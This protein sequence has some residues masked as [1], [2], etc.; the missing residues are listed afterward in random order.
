MPKSSECVSRGASRAAGFSGF[1]GLSVMALLLVT[2]SPTAVCAQSSGQ[3]AGQSADPPSGQAVEEIIVTAQRRA[4]SLQKVPIAVAAITGPQLAKQGI[5]DVRDLQ[6]KIPSLTASQSGQVIY[7]LRGVGNTAQNANDEASVAL[8]VDGV[9]LY[10][11]LANTLTLNNVER[12]EVLK[13][14]Q[15]TLFGRNTTGGVIQLITRDPMGPSN[16]EGHVGYGNY[17]TVTADAY[18]S[19]KLSDNAALGVALNYQDQ[20]QGWGHNV[21]TGSN[22]FTH[23]FFSAQVKGVFTPTSSTKITGYFLYNED[24]GDPFDPQIA[25]GVTRPDG[26]VSNPIHYDSYANTPSHLK[27]KGY[28]GYVRVDQDLGFADFVSITAHRDTHT[29][30]A[31]DYDASPLTIINAELP[32]KTRNLSQEI[33]LVSPASSAIKWLVGAYYFDGVAGYNPFGMSGLAFAPQGLA[34]YDVYGSQ[35]L[36]SKALFAQVTVPVTDATNV[37][38]GFRYTDERVTQRDT[39]VTLQFLNGGA[40][41]YTNPEQSLKTDKPTWRVSI[42]HSFS[43][44]VM[45]YA[46]YNRG[47]KSGG[48]SL[49][50]PTNDPGYLPEKLD[51]FEVGVKSTLLDGMLRLNAAGFLYKYKDIQVLEALTTGTI[52]VNAAAATIKGVE[53]DFQAR[54][55]PDWSVF[56][57]AAL[58]DS[59][60][61]HYYNA[62]GYTPAGTTFIIPDAAGARGVYAPRFTGSIGTNYTIRSEMGD[63]EF[64]AFLEHLSKQYVGP[65]NLVSIPEYTTANATVTWTAK[66]EHLSVSLWAKNLFDKYYLVNVLESPFGASQSPGAPRTFGV[67]FGVKY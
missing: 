49:S 30:F 26:V 20:G 59:Q 19:G 39:P 48:F 66:D 57:S 18:V 64:D 13:G 22:T 3:P 53:G 40:L 2:A 32:D 33:Q 25:P 58:L 11:G 9:Y 5:G 45:V 43:R 12:V 37:T 52:T 55:T 4:E 15:G 8:Y 50:K 16:F 42:D 63:V 54:I 21:N 10:G 1:G 36:E 44:D 23:N 6:A 65:G 61:D 47:V 24:H 31:F 67:R 17:R 41:G 14:P 27:S 62:V 56:G 7:F 51:A 34:G 60:Y 35:Q 28:L 46:S 29:D 38:G